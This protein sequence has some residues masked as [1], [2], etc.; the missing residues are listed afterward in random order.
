MVNFS[1][2]RLF[3]ML[4][5]LV[6]THEGYC[7][8]W[9]KGKKK[10]QTL[11]SAQPNSLNPSYQAE[12]Y[13]PKRAKSRKGGI[14]Y[15]ARQ[16]YYRRQELVAK[17]KRKAEREMLKPQYSDPSYFGHKRPPKRNRPGK[18]RYCKECGIRH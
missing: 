3:V 7:Q 15:D 10:E 18:L 4:I 9:K 17:E 16:N 14:S 11:Q 13:A 12:V 1:M 8:F 2:Q 6:T 5:L